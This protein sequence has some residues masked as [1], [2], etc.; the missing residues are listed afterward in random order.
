MDDFSTAAD[1]FT[2]H[3]FDAR[4]Y[5]WIEL[6]YSNMVYF[7]CR[8]I[9]TKV[10]GRGSISYLC[11][12]QARIKE[13]GLLF[14]SF[15]YLCISPLFPRAMMKKEDEK[16]IQSMQWEASPTLSFL[17]LYLWRYII[18]G[19]SHFNVQFSACFFDSSILC[20]PHRLYIHFHKRVLY[21]EWYLM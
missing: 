2:M 18:V 13:E 15:F 20:V 21:G 4:Y 6:N 7:D 12:S 9:S 17:L 1:Q 5:L 14:S 19:A 16:T 11:R 8:F 3:Y 10:L